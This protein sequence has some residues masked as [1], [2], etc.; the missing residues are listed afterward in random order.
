MEEASQPPAPQEEDKAQR[1]AKKK[2][3]QKYLEILRL[4]AQLAAGRGGALNEEQRAKVERKAAVAAQVAE[5]GCEL[6]VLPP[7]AAPAGPPAHGSDV[8]P[9]EVTSAMEALA[10]GGR[11]G[12]GAPAGGG[13]AAPAA[14]ARPPSQAL[15]YQQRLQH[16][17]PGFAY[18]FALPSPLPDMGVQLVDPMGAVFFEVMKRRAEGGEP[19]AASMMFKQLEQSAAQQGMPLMQL[20]VQLLAEFG[21]DPVTEE[22]LELADDQAALA[23]VEARTPPAELRRARKQFERMAEQ[24]LLQQ[25]GGVGVGGRRNRR[26]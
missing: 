12:G 21:I 26:R 25:M 5:L 15:A 18:F 1:N 3:R 6:P 17:N 20:R 10:M 23:W 4:E 11:S 2:L 24:L 8:T 13:A 19:R 7:S 14:P 9:E 22:V 16:D